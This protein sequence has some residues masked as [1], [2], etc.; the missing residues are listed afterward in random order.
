[1]SLSDQE[2]RVEAA[3]KSTLFS[4]PHRIFFTNV[5]SFDFDEDRPA[6]VMTGSGSSGMV[7]EI[8]R[9]LEEVGFP[10]A[11][12]QKAA[13]ISAAARNDQA[14]RKIAQEVGS[15]LKRRPQKTLEAAGLKRPPKP[16]QV[17]AVVHLI[18]VPHAANFSVPGS[19]K[20]AMVLMAF[21]AL[22]S[23]RV[24]D[25][26]VVVGPSSSFMP[27]EEEARATLTQ[28]LRSLRITGSKPRRTRL[29]RA[30]DRATLVLL[31]YQMAS[32]DAQELA[33]FLRR[34][35]VMFVLDESH[36]IK[37]LEGGKW[38]ETLIGIAPLATKRVIL[39]GT[40]MPNSILDLW[41][42]IRFLW[43]NNSP[44]GERE[45]F[46]YRAGGSDEPALDATRRALFPFYWRVRKRGPWPPEAT[47]LS[48]RNIDE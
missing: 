38:A 42:Q 31:T 48:D 33:A 35:K 10:I 12:N 22:R 15:K 7:N 44:L 11:L 9:Y 25:K 43:P 41:S 5:L 26:L 17:P 13:Q 46:R 29:Y 40:P 45:E 3:S 6:Y 14:A 23:S 4:P 36:N 39:S 8:I 1:M 27:W 32:N 37:R 21:A 2:L 20:T 19:G 28:G 30:A 16:Y 34:H 47:L 24:V 18:E